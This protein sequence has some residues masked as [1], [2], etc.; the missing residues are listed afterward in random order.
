MTGV[1]K[2]LN[3][4]TYDEIKSLKLNNTEYTI[5]TLKEVLSLINGSVPIIVEF[6]YDRKFGLLEKEAF[7]YLDNYKGEFCVKSFQPLI[8]FYIRCMR[9]KYIRGLLI[10]ISDKLSINVLSH[11]IFNILFCNPDFISCDK[12]LYKNKNI[13]RFK[14][15]KPVLAW[16]IKTNYDY[17]K[18]KN[19]FDG[20][21]YEGKIK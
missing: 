4:V 7:K 3:K 18:Y 6:K 16:T 8:V 12:N 20:I 10:G 21:I 1:D 17:E 19:I 11:S 14:K 9:P 13:I 15:N 5:P 2:N